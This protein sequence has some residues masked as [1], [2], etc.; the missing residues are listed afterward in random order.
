MWFLKHRY[1]LIQQLSAGGDFAPQ[2]TFGN[3]WRNA[4][5]SQK[6]RSATG[7]QWVEARVLLTILQCTGQHH[8]KES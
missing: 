1:H 3:V 5:L 2:G 8:N 7:I 4:L 6:E